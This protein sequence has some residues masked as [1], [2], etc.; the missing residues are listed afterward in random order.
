[1]IRLN[2]TMN[3]WTVQYKASTQEAEAGRQRMWGQSGVHSDT[4]SQK[5]N[6]NKKQYSVFQVGRAHG[7]FAPFISMGQSLKQKLSLQGRTELCFYY[8]KPKA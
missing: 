4:L 8:L 7:C 6:K 3:I 5:Q 1:M 2:E